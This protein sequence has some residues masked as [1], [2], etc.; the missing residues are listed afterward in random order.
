MAGSNLVASDIRITD[1]ANS[2]Y[3]LVK[4]DVINKDSDDHMKY[5]AVKILA[6]NTTLVSDS[7]NYYLEQKKD[8]ISVHDEEVYSYLKTIYPDIF[9]D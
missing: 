3:Y 1:T 6:T 5:E 2:K 7:F 4:V 9:V 8:S